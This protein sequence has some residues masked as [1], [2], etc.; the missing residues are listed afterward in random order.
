MSFSPTDILT[1]ASD[2]I[3]SVLYPQTCIICGQSVNRRSEGIACDNCWSKAT[4]FSGLETFCLKC[5]AFLSETEPL[6]DTYCGRC[7]G[8][9]YDRARAVGVYRGAMSAL[10]L[11]LK[12][13][14]HLPSQVGRWLEIAYLDSFP[15]FADVIIPV[16]LSRRRFKERGFNQ[17]AIIGMD[18]SKRT[19]IP[20]DELSLA[21]KIHTPIHRAGMDL[22][23]RESSVKNA[24]EVTR[25]KLIIGKNILLVDDIFTSGSTASYCAKA[26][27]K[28]GAVSVNVL[29]L[30][31]AV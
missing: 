20:M 25:P 3:L 26:L 13:T 7:D 9:F 15:I 6:I 16:P 21:R 18:L 29:T 14:P 4:I 11:N 17:A 19:A 28:N 22:K 23:A 12:R 31:R 8:H 24:F 30:G 5:G 2:S 1:S 10:I 27:K